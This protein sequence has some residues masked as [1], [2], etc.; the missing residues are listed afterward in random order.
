MPELTFSSSY[1]GILRLKLSEP[2]MPEVIR[3]KWANMPG[4]FLKTEGMEPVDAPNDNGPVF[5][6]WQQVEVYYEPGDGHPWKAPF[7]LMVNQQ[8]VLTSRPLGKGHK[9]TGSFTLQ[10]AVGFTDIEI[11]DV[12]GRRIFYLQTE[13]FP[14]KISYKEDFEAMVTDITSV[15]YNLV[16][17]HLRRTFALTTPR[18]SSKPSLLEYLAIIRML[19]EPLLQSLDLIIRSPHTQIASGTTMKDASQITQYH[20]KTGLW[21]RKHPH[22]LTPLKDKG[23]KIS[24][25]VYVTHLPEISRRVTRDTPENRFVVWAVGQILLTLDE[26]TCRLERQYVHQERITPVLREVKAFGQKLRKRLSHPLFAGVEGNGTPLQ[27]SPTL[28]FAAGYRDFY[29]K[30]QV[31]RKG[32]SISEDDIFRLDYRQISTLYEYWCFLKLVQILRDDLGFEPLSRDLIITDHNRLRISLKKGQ[33]SRV[34]FLRKSTGEKISLWFNRTFSSGETHTFTQVPDILL[35]LEKPGYQ[36]KFRFVMDAKYRLNS[37]T[38]DSPPADAMAQL[39]RYRDAI[40]TDQ[41]SLL[42]H[43]TADKIMGGIILFPYPEDENHF[44]DHDWYRSIRKVNLGAIPMVPGKEQRFLLLKE[45][46]Y[47]LLE[48]PPEA[49]NEQVVEYSRYDHKRVIEEAGK[50]V[51]IGIIPN[52]RFRQQRLHFHLEKGMYHTLLRG[53]ALEEVDYVAMYDQQTKQII[54]FGK[55]ET[56]IFAL[57]EDMARWG[58]TWDHRPGKE[59]YLVF[60]LND[61]VR[62]Q[63]PFRGMRQFGRR[64]TSLWGLK[65]AI[66]YEDDQYL[67]LYSY[68]W[69]RLWQEIRAIDPQAVVNFGKDESGARRVEIEFESQGG[70]CLCT[71]TGEDQLTL[72]TSEKKSFRAE[73]RA[74]VIRELLNK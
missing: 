43:T 58:K 60:R 30:F 44:R 71:L 42:T 21:L 29:Q 70:I 41:Q 53:P 3:R 50:K 4:E 56:K 15:V 51:L 1:S 32:L 34:R 46:L 20:P 25:G 12:N 72:T 66:R 40:L 9:L 73:L 49:L 61:I 55:V 57:A 52:D 23:L 5:F 17:D 2:G 28:M 64:Y 8:P 27:N 10:D 18:H 63:L 37:R 35:E 67:W 38:W 7:T 48:K 19:I 39:H 74:G 33:A 16:Y 54:G 24:A 31:L 26:L 11:N 36:Q 68:G 45:Y 14:R 59:K 69:L 22:V 47:G 62:C 65:Q 13:V 6:E